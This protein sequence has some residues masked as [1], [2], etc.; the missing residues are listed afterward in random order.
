MQ[1][2][3]TPK[4]NPKGPPPPTQRLAWGMPRAGILSCCCDVVNTI[5]K[6]VFPC[7]WG[8]GCQRLRYLFEKLWY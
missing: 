6:C 1:D 5:Q 2:R 3:D 8:I 4:K 7:P